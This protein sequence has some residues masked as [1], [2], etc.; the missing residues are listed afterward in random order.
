M[1]YVLFFGFLIWTI[2]VVFICINDAMLNVFPSDH[3]YRKFWFR[4]I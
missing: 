2:L 1:Y 3:P 4:Y